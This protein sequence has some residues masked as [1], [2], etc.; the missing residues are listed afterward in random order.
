MIFDQKGYKNLVGIALA[1][2]LLL[3]TVVHYPIKIYFSGRKFLKA[4]R[5]SGRI[6]GIKGQTINI[7]LTNLQISLLILSNS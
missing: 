6:E 5:L 1:V 2:Y 7:C 3:L 4:V